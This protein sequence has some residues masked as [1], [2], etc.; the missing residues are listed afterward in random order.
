[1]DY[2]LENYLRQAY[3]GFPKDRGKPII[4]LTTNFEG[5]D[6]TLRARYYRQIVAAG[7]VPLLV[8]PVA[9]ADVI[10]TTLDQI[11]A[12]VFTGAGD[13]DPRWM[14]DPLPA[15]STNIKE[16]RDLPELLTIRMAANR[17]MPI[18]GICR[19]IQMMAVAFG[20]HVAEDLTKDSHWQ[21]DK[22]IIHSQERERDVATHT[23]RLDKNSTLYSIYG[24][25]TI[26][27]NSFH[28][29]SVDIIPKD[30]RVTAT[31]DD[32]IAEAM[33]SSENKPFMGLQ[34]HPEWLG[35]N[36]RKVFDWLV[37]EA[38]LFKE[39]KAIHDKVLTIDS[40]CD[41]P[42]FFPQGA[43]FTSYDD[44]LKVDLSKMT[45]GRLDATTMVAYIPQPTGNQTWS[46]VAPIPTDSPFAYADLIFD[47]INAMVEASKKQIS[48]A[49]DTSS[50]TINKQEGRKSIMLGIENAL[51]IA[52]DISRVAYFKKRGVVYITL[53]HNGDN[54]VCDSA[55]RSASTWHGLSPFGR[56]LVEEMN[57]QGIMIDLS[58]AGER[59]FF[60]AM[61]TSELP[62]VCS[63]SNCKAICE[64][65]RNLSD[66]Q[67]RALARCGGVCQLTL[68]DG[69]VSN[70]PS[71][72]DILQFM[73]HVDHAVKVMGIEHVGIGS[74]FDGDGG[75]P[76]LNDAGEMTLFT[77][78]LLKRRF[79]ET[80]IR[81]IW[82]GNW[83]RVM[84]EY[85]EKTT[86][87]QSK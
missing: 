77:R 11:D 69:F 75:I 7:G 19:G 37:T 1:M 55:R 32:G 41:T 73:R 48:I 3:S 66:E 74:D 57:R 83:L 40:H 65:E 26:A 51:P 39:T 28:H 87:Q 84:G 20:G 36:G 30:F 52:D 34:W 18:L 23:V 14:G 59:S 54:Q 60:D 4:G 12:I 71:E 27:V 25:D 44:R 67:L 17:Q 46:D 85:A 6:V 64:H 47:K 45:D 13:C 35:E 10:A 70:N 21:S 78:Q 58:H 72:A 79:F 38:R 50:L 80:D 42:M 56:I 63:H 53:C 24:N 62:V 15:G 86:R 43:C 33:E 5:I 68:Y 81:K 8:P 82:G 16:E 9:D 49:R 31:A 22:G 2:C 29:Q 61:E 76:G